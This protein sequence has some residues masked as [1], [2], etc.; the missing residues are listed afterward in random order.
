MV[1]NIKLSI[2]AVMA[3][4]LII[5]CRNRGENRDNNLDHITLNHSEAKPLDNLFT[6]FSSL[7]IL[8]LSTDSIIVYD[9]DQIAFYEGK[10]FTL[11]SGTKNRLSIFDAYGDLLHSINGQT[12]SPEGYKY[13][14]CFDIDRKNKYIEIL[15]YH[16]RR[17]DRFDFAGRKLHSMSIDG[18]YL[19]F[20]K[21]SNEEYVFYAEN[22]TFVSNDHNNFYYYDD[23]L[24]LIKA[25]MP[26]NPLIANCSSIK[27]ETYFNS[28]KEDN[29]LYR[30][31]HS[32]TIFNLDPLG[33]SPVYKVDW[34]EGGP[35]EIPR[36]VLDRAAESPENYLQ[37]IMNNTDYALPLYSLLDLKEYLL[38]TTYYKSNYYWHL[39]DKR[40]QKSK[41]YK[42]VKTDINGLFQ[43]FP[44]YLSDGAGVG[45]R[46][47]DMCY[48][49]KEGILANN[50]LDDQ[51][52]LPE[53]AT[54]LKKFV[55]GLKETTGLTL[56][57]FELK[58]D[59]VN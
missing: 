40:L 43:I 13:S 30:D 54:E 11:E 23:A 42:I 32:D 45:H 3:M 9:P 51:K 38:L 49:F 55:G 36:D 1:Y 17:L 50:Y 37:L 31:L 19:R 24:H 6:L 41:S 7:R 4:G 57:Y 5:G 27:N 18:E 20:V 35:D 28:Y 10:I 39:Y 59:L 56:F 44:R 22:N 16:M 58:E 21:F 46:D 26:I 53:V 15:N 47:G 48:Y 33:L 14:H 12:D 8:Y 34:H 25:C 52:L 2:L 29:Y